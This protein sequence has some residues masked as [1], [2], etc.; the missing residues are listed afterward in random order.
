VGKARQVGALYGG[1]EPSLAGLK[2]LRFWASMLRDVEVGR[3]R[4]EGRKGEAFF[5]D[6]WEGET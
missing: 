1:R 3:T 5:L 2:T 6:R 4:G